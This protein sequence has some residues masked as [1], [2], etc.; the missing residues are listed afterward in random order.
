M[1][2][3]IW[4]SGRVPAFDTILALKRLRLDATEKRKNEVR[5]A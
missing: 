5:G 3:E 4:E 1:P 2:F